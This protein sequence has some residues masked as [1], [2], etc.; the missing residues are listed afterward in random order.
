MPYEKQLSTQERAT[1]EKEMR[2]AAKHELADLTDAKVAQNR[3]GYTLSQ[4]LAGEKVPEGDPNHTINAGIRVNDRFEKAYSKMA[5]VLKKHGLKT[6]CDTDALGN[7]DYFGPLPQGEEIIS[8]ILDESYG[9]A[10]EIAPPPL[11]AEDNAKLRKYASLPTLLHDADEAR[12]GAKKELADLVAAY[13]ALTKAEEAGEQFAIRWEL[14][15]GDGH[16][17]HEE[18]E[19]SDGDDH[20]KYMRLQ[21][22]VD[23][24]G[25]RVKEAQDAFDQK[26]DEVLQGNPN[27]VDIKR[28]LGNDAYVAGRTP[29]AGMSQEALEKL[30]D[31]A[32]QVADKELDAV[33]A[34]VVGSQRALLQECKF[35][36]EWTEKHH[37]GF[38][39]SDPD[40]SSADIE[41][42]NRVKAAMPEAE[43]HQKKAESDAIRKIHSVLQK[44]GL[45]ADSAGGFEV[46]QEL[47]GE[48]L[49]GGDRACW[50]A[51][52]V[53]EAP[54]QT[55]AAEPQGKSLD[56]IAAA[57]SHAGVGATPLEDSHGVTAQPGRS[58]GPRTR[59]V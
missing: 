13:K 45:T 34:A 53:L 41:E 35:Q 20:R 10:E 43:K 55:T 14:D 47:L 28:R 49:L 5:A 40:V 18:V 26:L 31:E 23:E 15:H 32:H 37:Y 21:H 7:P 16:S 54:E 8:D 1:I 12:E 59:S 52:A 2:E 36:Q 57:G 46:T 48:A 56:H 39:T 27:D 19:L 42:Y 4:A 58:G 44:H 6:G 11:T 24:A 33:S 38:A 50:G 22:A 51:A 25:P 17:F 3:T 29:D 30:K 9:K